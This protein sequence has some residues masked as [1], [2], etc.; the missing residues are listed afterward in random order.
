M[1]QCDGGEQASL[2][3]LGVLDESEMSTFEQHLGACPSCLLEVRK[4]GDVAVELAGTLPASAPPPGL[5]HKVLT[6]AALPRGIVALVRGAEMNWRPT[7]FEGVH[8]ARLFEDP[9]SGDL[10]SLVK[11]MPGAYFP[12]HH[13]AGIEHCY[14]LE[15]DLVFEDH[16]LTRGDYAAA[17][18]DEDHSATTTKHGCLLFIV[19]QAQDQVHAR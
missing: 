13:H 3:G 10:A 8:V 11:L 6:Q 9:I 7:P 5:R 12:S 15:G 16:T 17:G 4:F 2:Y 19:Y 14:V 1:P 18:P